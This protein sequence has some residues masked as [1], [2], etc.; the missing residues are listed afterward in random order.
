MSDHRPEP[1]PDEILAR[2]KQAKRAARARKRGWVHP[3]TTVRKKYDKK[4]NL[5]VPKKHTRQAE[6]PLSQARKF[7]QEN[8]DVAG[9]PEVDFHM[10]DCMVRDGI[11]GGMEP[12]EINAV[13]KAMTQKQ[14]IAKNADV[15]QEMA[16]RTES[17]LRDL[18]QAKHDLALVNGNGN[19]HLPASRLNGHAATSDCVPTL[20]PEE[21]KAKLIARL[22]EIDAE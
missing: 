21:E 11:T 14:H 2:A 18:Q 19:G 8:H 3:G 4:G 15:L 9:T 10:A 16:T 12:R 13:C 7:V 17:A 6:R 22:K 1:T 5:I 20:S